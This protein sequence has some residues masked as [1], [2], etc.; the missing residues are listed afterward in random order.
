GMDPSAW[1]LAVWLCLV[2]CVAVLMW[3][4]HD[5]RYR[6][7]ACLSRLALPVLVGEHGRLLLGSGATEFVCSGGHSI[8]HVSDFA[9]SWIDAES[10]THLDESCR[11]LFTPEEKKE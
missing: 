2:L 5:Q 4:L 1:G 9:T 10:W 11:T 7:P 8:M 3:S 6:C